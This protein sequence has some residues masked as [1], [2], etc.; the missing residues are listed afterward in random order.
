MLRAYP[1]DRLD[2]PPHV[3]PDRPLPVKKKTEKTRRVAKIMHVAKRVAKYIH[4]SDKWI[5]LRTELSD[6]KVREEVPVRPKMANFLHKALPDHTAE[7]PSKYV[8]EQEPDKHVEVPVEVTPKRESHED[9]DGAETIDLR[10][11]CT[12]RFRVKQYGI[13]KEGDSLMI[14][15]SAVDLDTPG[16][17]IVK[18]KYF[19]LTRELWDLLNRNDVDKAPFR[20][21]ICYDIKAF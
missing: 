16:V 4:P 17:I 8:V 21:M 13:W 10:E 11:L 3:K 1:E 18:G 7:H 5:A 14:G 6:A 19:K 2:R 15:N 12:L 20:L 9:D